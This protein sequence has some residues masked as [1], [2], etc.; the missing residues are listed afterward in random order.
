MYAQTAPNHIYIHIPMCTQIY[1]SP[2]TCIIKWVTFNLFLLD[3]L[4]TTEIIPQK[5]LYELHFTYKPHACKT[6]RGDYP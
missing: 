5:S 1:T 6:E 2:H 3:I 4:L